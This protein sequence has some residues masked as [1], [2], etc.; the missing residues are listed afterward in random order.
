MFNRQQRNGILLLVVLN[1]AVLY[2]YCFVDFSEEPLLDI[3]S[4]TII[5]MQHELDSLRLEKGKARRPKVYP[6][7]PNFLT[8][9]RAYTLGIPS[10]AIEK[11]NAFRA[12]DQWVNSA[13]D[14][15]KVT[16][17]SDSLLKVVS[18]YFKFPEWVNRSNYKPKSYT[19][20][21]KA[22]AFSEKTDLNSATEA[23]LQEIYGIGP[24]LSK[25]IVSYRE[26][27]GGFANDVQ[28]YA[29]Y[30]LSDSV[31][32]RIRNRFTVKSPKSLVTYSVHTASA[33]DIATIPGISFELAKEIWEFIKLR[34]GNFDFSEL[35]KIEG[36]TR[37]KLQ[38]IQLYLSVE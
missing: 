2:I 25:R 28:L 5:A 30:G 12:K 23:G 4:P 16:G 27:I 19:K 32:A 26:T 29:V 8:E 38:L 36:V 20:P 9:Y 14:F 35:T 7:N 11:L 17:I 13:T 1:L 31:I 15:Q 24:A 37:G 10:E 6:F 21:S 3:S 33:S 34:D 22:L 18:P